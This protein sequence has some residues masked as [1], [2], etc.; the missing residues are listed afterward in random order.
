VCVW[1][2]DLSFAFDGRK[3]E[4]KIEPKFRGSKCFGI[5]LF[6]SVSFSHEHTQGANF[7]SCAF[8]I[9]P[10]NGPPQF[11]SV[12]GGGEKSGQLP[13]AEDSLWLSLSNEKQRRAAVKVCHPLFRARQ[14]PAGQAEKWSREACLSCNIIAVFAT[15]CQRPDRSG[16]LSR[17]KQWRPF[18]P[19]G[20]RRQFVRPAGVSI[21]REVA[22][23]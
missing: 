8:A 17:A 11:A 3:E 13:G 5:S 4:L 1:A 6:S 21:G 15:A 2:A 14:F 22:N 10:I 16:S 18:S 12:G 7:S 20:S 23:A 9:S 19:F